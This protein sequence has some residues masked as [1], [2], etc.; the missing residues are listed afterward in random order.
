[1]SG[2]WKYGTLQLCKKNVIDFERE[3]I[4]FQIHS[5]G[6]SRKQNEDKKQKKRLASKKG[7]KRRERE[8]AEIKN[9]MMVSMV[10]MCTGFLCNVVFLDHYRLVPAA[11]EGPRPHSYCPTTQRCSN[12][13]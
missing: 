12:S 4:L 8:D 10:Q 3:K 1:V 13:R 2:P 7:S 6:C 5:Q 11:A 9:E